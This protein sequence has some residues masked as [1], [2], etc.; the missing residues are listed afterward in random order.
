MRCIIESNLSLIPQK[1]YFCRKC[2]FHSGART[3][4]VKLMEVYCRFIT[5]KVTCN[6]PLFM[7]ISIPLPIKVGIHR[8][9]FNPTVIVV[10]KILEI[11]FHSCLYLFIVSVY[12]NL[13]VYYCTSSLSCTISD[14][15]SCLSW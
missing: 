7:S 9:T 6:S 2:N 12:L 1:Y 8:P 3:L 4:N 14:Q 13:C 10:L 5:L 11:S 15:V